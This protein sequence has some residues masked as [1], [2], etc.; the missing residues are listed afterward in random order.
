[1][2]TQDIYTSNQG[3]MFDLIAFRVYGSEKYCVDLMLA[4]PDYRDLAI[5]DGGVGI[6][7]PDIEVERAS[8]LPPW[9]A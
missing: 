9:K 2:A 7:C 3:D 8:P 1:M 5:F 4:N 6:V